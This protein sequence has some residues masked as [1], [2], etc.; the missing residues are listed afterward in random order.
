MAGRD[1]LDHP[2]VPN[3]PPAKAARVQDGARRAGASADRHSP[4]P[5]ARCEA[6]RRLRRLAGAAFGADCCGAG[7][8]AAR[9]DT[10]HPAQDQQG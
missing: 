4:A 1:R 7:G 9:P 5:R 2:A 3:G 10:A 8:V 6:D